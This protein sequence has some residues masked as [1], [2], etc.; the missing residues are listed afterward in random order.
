ME[1]A[2]AS[3]TL[4]FAVDVLLNVG[5]HTA[6]ERL[7]QERMAVVVRPG[8]PILNKPFNMDVYLGA[9]HILVSSRSEGPGIEDFEL[10]RISAQRQIAL[11]CQHYFAA[12]R[13][14]AGTDLL[15]TM[16]E[17]YARIIAAHLRLEILPTPTDMM[18]MEIHLYWHRPYEAEPALA[19]LRERIIA[20]SHSVTG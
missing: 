19:W 1:T 18:P 8:H 20:H 2:L 16:P 11:R 13:V 12:C 6:H 14:V 9:R 15:L 7:L 17:S 10:S 3:G 4:D 5:D